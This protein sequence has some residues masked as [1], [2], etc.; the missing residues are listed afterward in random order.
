ATE[1]SSRTAPARPR[2]VALV[3]DGGASMAVWEPTTIAFRTVLARSGYF[4]E[5]RSFVLLPAAGSMGSPLPEHS[6]SGTRRPDPTRLLDQ[7]HQQIFLVVTDGTGGLW[8]NPQLNLLLGLWGRLGPLAIVNPYPQRYG[9]RS[10]IWPLP[11]QLSAP[12]PWA[13]NDRLDVR[14]PGG[15]P[16]DASLD[17]LSVPVPVIELNP[18]W[19][20]WWASLLCQP[21]DWVDAL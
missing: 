21:G 20:G 15:D 3:I 1:A 4:H 13:S 7:S 16:F 2:A 18:R 12:A 19:I 10:R 6:A 17:R 5:V 14:T 9:H 11:V 8:R